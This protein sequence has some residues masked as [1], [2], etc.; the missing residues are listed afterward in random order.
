VNLMTEDNILAH[1]CNQVDAALPLMP[2]HLRAWVESH[3]I[4]PRKVTVF[5]DPDG[6]QPLQVWLVTDDT[7]TN[8]VYDPAEGRFGGAMQLQNDVTLYLGSA[9]SFMMAVEN[10]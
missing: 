10:L 6:K 3:R 2:D 8:I 1:I 9:D 7:A 5:S 4:A